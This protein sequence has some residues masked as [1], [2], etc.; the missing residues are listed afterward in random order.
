[1]EKTVSER[2]R[3]GIFILVGTVLLV[4]AIYLIGSRQNMFGNTFSISAVFKNVGGLQQGNNV[5]FSGINVGTVKK[6]EMINDT[7]IRVIMIIDKEILGHI[8]KNAVATVGSDGLVGSMILNIVPGKGEVAAVEEGDEIGSYSK[9]ATEDMMNTLSVTNENAALLTADL[10][11]ITESLIAGKGTVGRL[12]NDTIMANDLE[13][14]IRNLKALSNNANYSVHELNRMLRNI[15]KEESV[16][17]VLLNDSLS[18]DRVRNVIA[19]L[20]LASKDIKTMS[21][22]LSSI[23]T[24]LKGGEGAMNYLAEDTGLVNHLESTMRNIDEGTAR[25]NQNMEALKHNMFFRGYFKKQERKARK[26]G[27]N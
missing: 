23:V 7:A 6:L 25:F 2:M 14:T 10:L 22:D 3:L 27:D 15:Q 5:R 4:L 20:E 13:I 26:E 8:K 17:G 12:M 1:M 11:Q 16:A 9:I 21:A 18:G 19:D 24:D